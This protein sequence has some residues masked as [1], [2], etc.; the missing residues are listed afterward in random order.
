MSPR[1]G[2][3]CRVS[4][5]QQS[6]E[7]QLRELKAY[8]AAKG[9]VN[10]TVF[11]DADQSGTKTSRPEFDRMLASAKAKEID[12][13]MVWRFDRASRSTLHLLEIM[14]ELGSWGV[15]FV[16]LREQ[17][18]TSTP[19]G[20]LMFTLIAGFSQ[21]ERDV[22]SERTKAAMR[23]LKAEGKPCGR[24]R[25]ADWGKV[26][27]LRAKGLKPAAISKETGISEAHCRRIIKRGGVSGQGKKTT[28][29]Y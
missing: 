14:N 22:I 9:W 21:F 29:L 26:I 11:Q 4:T 28:K 15:D 20:K 7:T 25:Q 27:E 5:D 3:Y 16:S 10:V 2:L 13:V 19:S 18:D 6:N 17:V 8:C 24:S 23:R 1:I 12:I